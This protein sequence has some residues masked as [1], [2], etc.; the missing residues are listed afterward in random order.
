MDDVALELESQ[1]ANNPM[2]LAGPAGPLDSEQS[3]PDWG[4]AAR[5][6]VQMGHLSLSVGER[7][8]SDSARRE[9]NPD[10]VTAGNL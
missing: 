5:Q 4:L 10:L 6:S 8:D 2:R 7:F 9:L 1:P 3:E